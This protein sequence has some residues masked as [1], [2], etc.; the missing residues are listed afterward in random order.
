MCFR[1]RGSCA[2]VLLRLRVRYRAYPTVTAVRSTMPASARSTR[3]AESSDPIVSSVTSIRR[4]VRVLRVAA[5]RTQSVA[6]ITAAQVFVPQ[7][8]D[9][10]ASLSLNELAAKT[11]TDRSSVADVVDR[12]EAQRLV[13]RTVDPSDRRRAATRITG[14]GR[15]ILSRTPNAPTTTLIAAIRALSPS[16]RVT[17]AESLNR[18]TA[19]LGV[20]NE[21]ATML[22]AEDAAVGA[23][24]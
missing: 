3:P 21:P 19:A 7:Q 10:D 13:D 20:T 18:L 16:E 22:F 15:R 8:F 12:L 2:M 5:R 23:P 1:A 17:L 14:A 11:L 4:L 9:G 24:S 6:G